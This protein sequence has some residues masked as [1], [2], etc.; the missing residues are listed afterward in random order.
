VLNP[1]VVVNLLPEL[2]VSVDLLVDG[3]WPGER[4]MFGAE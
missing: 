2:R 1:K 4:S 3:R